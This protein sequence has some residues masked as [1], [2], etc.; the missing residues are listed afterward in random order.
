METYCSD[1]DFK[2]YIISEMNL[3][4][5]QNIRKYQDIIHSFF[6]TLVLNNIRNPDEKFI[7][8][9]LITIR[10]LYNHFY[11]EIK[12]WSINNTDATFIDM[13]ARQSEIKQHFSENERKKIERLIEQLAKFDKKPRDFFAPISFKNPKMLRSKPRLIISNLERLV[14]LHF[15]G[16]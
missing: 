13:S 11:Q 16:K 1:I 5:I 14:E 7:T 12:N 6:T 8:L 3:F 15:S 10:E 2:K 4:N 9:I